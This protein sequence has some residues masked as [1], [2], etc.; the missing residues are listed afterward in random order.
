MKYAFNKNQWPNSNFDS[1]TKQAARKKTNK[2][3]YIEN[4]TLLFV[5]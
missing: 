4:E 3:A 5:V 2:K 1:S